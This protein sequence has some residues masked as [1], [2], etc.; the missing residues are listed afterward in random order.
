[1][2][3]SRLV[4]LPLRVHTRQLAERTPDVRIALE[5]PPHLHSP[6]VYPLVLVQRQPERPEA[7]RL[8]D[9]LASAAAAEVFRKAG[10]GL[11]E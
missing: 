3:P 8:Y 6:I 2:S 5:I 9:Y 4:L 10:F 7:Q 1:M 11:A